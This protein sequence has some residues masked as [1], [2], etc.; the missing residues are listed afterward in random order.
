MSA[1][2]HSHTRR[3]FLKAAGAAGLGS[4][5]A[6]IPP[7]AGASKGPKTIP[8]RPFGKTGADVSI[9]SYGGSLDTSMS[10]LVLRQAFKW[11]VT[12]WD[13]ANSYMGGKS[14]KGIGKY[15][16][17]YPESRK[18]I[19]LVTKSHAW[20][21][22]GM[23]QDLDLS[24]ERMKTDYI[25]LFFIHSV[26]HISDLDDKTK[27]WADK[28]KAQGKIRFFGFSTHR[29]MEACMLHA[30]KLGWIDGIMMSYN[31]RMM[32][33]DEMKRAVEACAQAKLKA[34]WDNPYIS[35]ICSEMPNMTILM[36]NVAAAV[37]KTKLSLWDMGLL[38]QYAQETRS[39]YCAGCADICEPSIQ[40]DVP[41]SDVM[42]CLMYAR[43][44]GNHQRAKT[45][46]QKIP[47]NVRKEITHMDYSLAEKRCPQNM[48]IGK[49][50]K[51]AID[52]FS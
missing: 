9:L 36:S 28:K 44:Y 34:V 48:A 40:G 3:N 16:Q 6:A 23:S 46:F 5:F 45:R 29:N 27:V 4:I 25:D 20:T 24:L 42:R 39:Q 21:L 31:Y 51:E 38:R 52:V 50:M 10:L 19:F 43:S 1:I 32:H 17:K 30:S 41:V 18:R 22:K 7:F 26:S 13:T 33:T 15:L 11:G 47:V 2:K 8:T 49:L 12:Y 37:D 14:E 35:S